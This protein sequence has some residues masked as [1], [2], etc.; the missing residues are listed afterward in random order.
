MAYQKVVFTEMDYIILNT[1]KGMIAGMADFLGESYEFVLHS[2]EDLEHSVIAIINGMHTGRAVGVSI[3]DLA[4]DMLNEISKDKD[5]YITYF[6]TNKKGEPLKCSTIAIRG[7]H[8]KIIGLLCIN[9][10][11]NSSVYNLINDL[12]PKDRIHSRDLVKE[13][14]VENSDELIEVALNSAKSLVCSDT[15]ISA[16]NKNKKIIHILDEKGIFNIKDAVIK[17]AALMGI[18]KNT[19]YLHLRNKPQR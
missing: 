10:Y 4:L 15:T 16:S 18:S 19:V 12:V 1:Y 7:E 14:F 17:V 2:M 5:D 6:S 8:G 9:F 3:T 13:S 11:L